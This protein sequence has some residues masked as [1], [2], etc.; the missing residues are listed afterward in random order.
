MTSVFG[1][2]LI[3]TATTPAELAALLR[4]AHVAVQTIHNPHYMYCFR[5]QFEAL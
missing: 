5:Q 1:L 4:A 2:P 3:G